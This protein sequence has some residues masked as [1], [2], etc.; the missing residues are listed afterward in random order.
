MS[1]KERPRQS[2]IFRNRPRAKQLICFDDMKFAHNVRPTD[3]DGAGGT[4]ISASIDF[5]YGKDGFIFYEVKYKDAEMDEGQKAHLVA[6][7]SHL[8]TP[9]MVLQVSH[10]IHDTDDDIY[11]ADCNVTNRFYHDPYSKYSYWSDKYNGLSALEATILFIDHHCKK[12]LLEEHKAMLSAIQEKLEKIN[13][14]RR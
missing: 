2:P 12:Y 13:E 6:I 1:N 11:L 9:S 14:H 4:G 7:S 3:I 8:T 10:F 5:N